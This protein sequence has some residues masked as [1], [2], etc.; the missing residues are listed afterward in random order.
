MPDHTMPKAEPP[1]TTHAPDDGRIVAGIMDLTR[2]APG[3]RTAEIVA[4]SRGG[5]TEDARVVGCEGYR[6]T[7]LL[8]LV[9]FYRPIALRAGHDARMPC[10]VIDGGADVCLDAFKTG[11][12]GVVAVQAHAKEGELV[13]G[14]GIGTDGAIFGFCWVGR[15]GKYCRERLASMLWERDRKSSTGERGGGLS[16][17]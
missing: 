13:V 11:L 6:V 10:F 2:L 3:C 1:K 15:I 17:L 9:I 5:V 8:D 12:R 16:V 4:A 14:L 7:V